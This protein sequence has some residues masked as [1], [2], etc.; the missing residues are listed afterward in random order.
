MDEEANNSSKAEFEKKMVRNEKGSFKKMTKELV[1][2][3]TNAKGLRSQEKMKAWYEAM[4]K[5]D[6]FMIFVQ[7]TH[8]TCVRQLQFLAIVRKEYHVIFKNSLLT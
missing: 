7:E 3:T 2:V 8:F 5:Y 6:A 1:F 4:K